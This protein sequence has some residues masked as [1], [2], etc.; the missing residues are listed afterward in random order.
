MLL[1]YQVLGLWI[2][3]VEHEQAWQVFDAPAI[4]GIWSP[5]MSK[6]VIEIKIPFEENWL[7]TLDPNMPTYRALAPA[8]TPPEFM[9][10]RLD[11]TGSSKCR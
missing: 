5:D 9:H 6:M 11:R 3:D 8:L 4:S 7:V 10:H 2:F 1:P